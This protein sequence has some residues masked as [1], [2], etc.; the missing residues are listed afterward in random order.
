MPGGSAI[1]RHLS[2]AAPHPGHTLAALG[3]GMRDGGTVDA[4]KNNEQKI[5]FC[6]RTSATD[7]G[8]TKR[9]REVEGQERTETARVRHAGPVQ[10]GSCS[11]SP[12]SAVHEQQRLHRRPGLHRPDVPGLYRHP[13]VQR[14]PGLP[15]RYLPNS[16]PGPGTVCPALCPPCQVCN[17]ATGQCEVCSA[18]CNV[19][20]LLADRTSKCGNAT[21]P[22]VSV[23]CTTSADCPEGRKDCVR[24]ITDLSTNETVNVCTDQTRPC[25]FE[26]QPCL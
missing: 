24:T 9:L 13:S 7:V 17:S 1:G 21:F 6:H 3:L 19:C 10:R 20:V 18:N 22:L 25:C 15:E 14:Q 8:V 12:G 4:K 26:V 11:G 16:G 5:R 2:Y 23:P